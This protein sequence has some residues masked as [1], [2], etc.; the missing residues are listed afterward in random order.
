MDPDPANPFKKSDPDPVFKKTIK[1]SVVTGTGSQIFFE[2]FYFEALTKTF[3][4]KIKKVKILHRYC[5]N[6][7]YFLLPG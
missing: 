6:F 4:R 5:I 3:Y 7:L 1:F 2:Y